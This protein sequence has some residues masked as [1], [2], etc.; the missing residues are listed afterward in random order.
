MRRSGTSRVVVILSGLLLLAVVVVAAARSSSNPL[1]TTGW[2]THPRSAAARPPGTGASS[3]PTLFGDDFESDTMGR[4]PPSGWE[5]IDGAWRGVGRDG[6][7]VVSHGAGSPYGHMVAGSPTWSDYEVGA[8]VK[9]TPLTTGFAGVLGRYQTDTDYYECVVHHAVAVQLWRLRNG[10]GME[11]GGT[12]I[13]IDTARF[14][15]VELSMR[16][17]QLTCS[18]DGV[19][20]ATVSDRSLTAGRVGLVAS[21]A[22]AAEFDNVQVTRRAG[23]A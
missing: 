13:A 7:Q 5:M 22:E 23:G 21:T 6:S 4:N 16:G 9:V 15:R 19:A 2:G 3:D 10:Q 14:H 1:D 12:Q 17:D 20:M 18:M 8:D 11:L